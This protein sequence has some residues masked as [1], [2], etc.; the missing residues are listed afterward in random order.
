[1]QARAHF[2]QYDDKQRAFLDFVLQQYV[3]DGV[4]ELQPEKL[5]VILQLKYKSIPDATRELGEVAR[6]RETFVGFQK[7]LYGSA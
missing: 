5:S 3:R 2:D 7:W 6:I 4:A 1:M